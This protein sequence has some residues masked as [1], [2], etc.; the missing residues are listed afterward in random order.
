KCACAVLSA[1]RTA[2]KGLIQASHEIE[3]FLGRCAL[4]IKTSLFIIVDIAPEPV[5][6]KSG[7]DFDRR[8]AMAHQDDPQRL[9]RGASHRLLKCIKRERHVSLKSPRGDKLPQIHALS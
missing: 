4:R 1:R 7:L 8:L 5:M 6:A 3:Q 2:R 9:N